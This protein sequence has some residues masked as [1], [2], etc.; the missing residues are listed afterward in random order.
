MQ[1][2]EGFESLTAS[3]LVAALG[4]DRE[5]LLEIIR[6]FLRD[7]PA[8]LQAVKLEASRR[9][10]EALASAAHLLKGSVANFGLSPLYDVA[11]ELEHSARAND[12]SKL[13]EIVKRFDRAFEGF[14]RALVRMREELGT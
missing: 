5:L 14:E 3:R 9:Q 4:G 2:D 7:A 10:P 11:R 12:L 6:L 1:N 13:P 8:M